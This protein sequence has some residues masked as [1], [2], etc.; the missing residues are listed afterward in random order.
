MRWDDLSP[1]VFK[2]AEPFPH[3]VIDGIWNGEILDSILSE[4]PSR[5]DAAWITYNGAEEVGK[6]CMSTPNHWGYFTRELFYSTLLAPEFAGELEQKIGIGPLTPD[7]IGGGLHM[8]TEGGRLQSHVDF[9][10]HPQNPGLRRRI[11]FLIFLNKDWD[12]DNGGVLYLGKNREVAV[13]PQFNRTVIFECSDLSWHG[14]PD[15]IVGDHARKSLACYYYTPAD[16]TERP[17]STVWNR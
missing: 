10:L 17:H 14:H 9:N 16:G 12:D 2:E 15:P 3:A 1:T 11:N 6:H 7:T 5:D 4:W 13:S 8:T